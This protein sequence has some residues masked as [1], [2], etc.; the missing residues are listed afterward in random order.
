MREAQVKRLFEECFTVSDER[1]SSLLR[2]KPKASKW[3]VKERVAKRDE[4]I[5]LHRSTLAE[6]KGDRSRFLDECVKMERALQAELRERTSAAQTLTRSNHELREQLQAE[7]QAAR[8]SEA[9]A[10]SL[11]EENADLRQQLHTLKQSKELLADAKAQLASAEAEVRELRSQAQEASAKEGALSEALK[12]AEEKHLRDLEERSN[13]LSAESS[14]QLEL[15]REES[16]R[17][18]AEAASLQEELGSARGECEAAREQVKSLESQCAELR[19]RLESESQRSAHEAQ[20]TE[21]LES[22]LSIARDDLRQKEQ[23][24]M[25]ALTNVSEVQ[26]AAAKREDALRDELRSLGTEK[27]S[28]T[29]ELNALKAQLSA[30]SA[31]SS[32]ARSEIGGLREELEKCKSQCAEGE[33]ALSAARVELATSSEGLKVERELRGRAEEREQEERNERTAATAQLLALQAQHRSDLEAAEAAARAAESAADERC[34]ALRREIEKRL[35]ALKEAEERVTA[36]EAANE[37]LRESLSDAEKKQNAS[38]AEELAELKGEMDVLKRQKEELASRGVVLQ[39]DAARRIAEMEQKV[40]EGEAQRRKLHNLVQELRGN[41]RVFARIRP[42]LPSDGDGGK[43]SCLSAHADAAGLEITS[44]ALE[45][46]AAE[47][48]PGEAR[49]EASHGFTFDRVFAPSVGQQEVFEEVSEFV[50]SALDGYHVCL[51][52]YGQTGSGKTH[53]MQGSGD[54]P[55]RGIIP[56]A[57]EQV[58]EYKDRLEENGW[59]ARS[60]SWR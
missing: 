48:R 1:I 38:A 36:L 49:R 24:L 59:T 32:A 50:Q 35:E 7:V 51:F 14:Q 18:T 11:G 44:A 47:A 52:S 27:E 55:M 17:A 15:L 16:T 20:R 60:C 22:D 25:A 39:E 8:E 30:A 19:G 33:R 41:V 40:R 2:M 43:V 45:K 23:S 6:E 58:G 56:R 37:C 10:T 28:F 21:R 34:D 46:R 12:A 13:S 26:S 4:L 9:S 57:M 5:N 29:S 54:G 42:F 31:E 53:T 3:D